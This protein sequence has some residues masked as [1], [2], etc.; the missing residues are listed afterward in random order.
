MYLQCV[1]K[2]PTLLYVSCTDSGELLQ[3]Y[4]YRVLKEIHPDVGLSMK[5]ISVLDNFT[6]DMRDKIANEA[7]DL[8]RRHDRATLSSREVCLHAPACLQI[9]FMQ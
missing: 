9:K 1:L 5:A 7:A 2:R 4:L 8:C 3:I 6:K